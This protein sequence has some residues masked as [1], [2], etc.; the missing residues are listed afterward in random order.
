MKN[1]KK[2]M[3]MAVLTGAVS[4]GAYAQKITAAK[5][6]AAVKAAFAKTNPGVTNVKWEKEDGKFEA[7]YTMGGHEMSA[8]YDAN[9]TMTES[10]MGIKVSELPTSVLSYVSANRKG[11]KIKE[12]AKITKAGGEV[13]YEAQVNGKDMIFD[14]K[15]SFI[16]EVK[17]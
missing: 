3:L 13:N 2:L 7:G 5:V 9:G 6:P 1:L 17:D 12:A 15:G 14:A 4:S 8:L 10:E 16:K 11:A